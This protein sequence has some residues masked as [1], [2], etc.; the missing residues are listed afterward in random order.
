MKQRTGKVGR[1]V[2]IIF[3]ILTIIL[4]IIELNTKRDVKIHYYEEKIKAGQV[5]QE[6]MRRIKFEKEKRGV[7]I[8]LI[9]DPNQTGII[10][11]QYTPITFQ[12]SDL[13]ASLTSTNPNFV[14]I[15]IEMFKKLKI[16]SGDTIAIGLDGSYPAVN[17][18]LYAVLR[19]MDIKAIIITNVS[20]AMWGAND[21]NFTWLDMENV[22]YLDRLAVHK[23]TA[24]S[25]G[26]EDDLGRGFSPQARQHLLEAHNRNQVELI[27]S[28]NLETNI[29]RHLDIYLKC[30]KIKAFINIGKSVAN[31]GENQTNFVNGII[32]RL[33]SKYNTQS[34][35]AEML[36]KNIP[37]INITDVNKIAARYGLPIAPVPL[38]PLGKGKLFIEKRFSPTAALVFTIIILICLF[39]VIRYD[40]EYYLSRKKEQ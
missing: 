16:K 40:L 36:K 18:A 19:V 32:R 23:T 37:V 14:A 39:L 38:P 2:L 1:S 28:E 13:S 35:I 17:M 29:K 6:M 10:G 33:P 11:Q 27:T 3:T 20:S 21:P 34:I 8:D 7:V 15:F 5:F 22:L 31:I 30:K 24:A 9:N 4:F 12:R 25:L 26:G